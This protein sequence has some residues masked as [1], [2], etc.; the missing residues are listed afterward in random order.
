[1]VSSTAVT[2]SMTQKSKEDPKNVN[3]YVV[4]TLV[5]SCIMFLRV[6]AIVFFVSI[7]V[8][9]TFFFPALAMFLA[10]LIATLYFYRQSRNTKKITSDESASMR[11]PFRILPALQFAGIIVLVKFISGVGITYKDI[12]G[13]NIF[14]GALGIL[15]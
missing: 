10:F 6:F 5:A 9:S 13:E 15:S 7:S 4:G 11:S 12:W 14:Y 8:F 1:M 3:S 2:A